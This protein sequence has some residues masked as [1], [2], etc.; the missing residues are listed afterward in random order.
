MMRR[1]T[2][3][4]AVLLAAALLATA[5]AAS[6]SPP[7]E[8]TADRSGSEASPASSPTAA[9]PGGLGEELDEVR[10]RLGIPIPPR[11][12]DL[13]HHL[14]VGITVLSEMG[15]G[16]HIRGRLGPI[17]LEFSAAM[18]LEYFVTR[19]TPCP[20]VV[21][22]FPFRMTGSLIGYIA[23]DHEISHSVRAGVIWH[24]IYGWGAIVGY[25]AE[26]RLVDWLVL[27]GGTGVIVM[28][29]GHEHAT[30]AIKARCGPDAKAS[31]TSELTNRAWLYFGLG[32]T[33]YL[34]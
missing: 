1:P 19:D 17:A 32:L 3:P 18:A 8:A 5:G 7:S 11:P 23:E 34:F 2:P 10:L 13:P 12:E 20:L 16:G 27:E 30:C 22:E 9:P 21:F 33:A 24:G 26:V 25:R 6:A 4:L 28:P 15:Y 31:P 29:I 14:G